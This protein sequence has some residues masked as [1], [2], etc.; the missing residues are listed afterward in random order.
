MVKDDSLIDSRKRLFSGGACRC[1][2]IAVITAALLLLVSFCALP[3][4]FGTSDDKAIQNILSGVTYGFP[5]GY[6]VFSNILL[7]AP[8]ASLY[9]V[10]HEVPLWFVT[11]EVFQFIAATVFCYSCLCIVTIACEGRGRGYRIAACAIS[12]AACIILFLLPTIRPTFSL[13]SACLAASSV[14]AFYSSFFGKINSSHERS[15]LGGCSAALI[16]CAYCVRS[17]SG[18]AGLVILGALFLSLCW[19]F[20]SGAYG[21]ERGDFKRALLVAIAALCLIGFAWGAQK[22]AYSSPEWVEFQQINSVRGK[23]MDYDHD[24]YQN[25]PDLYESVGWDESLYQLVQKW[26]FMDDRVGY[27]SFK[28][29]AK[30]SQV[31][32]RASI[33]AVVTVGSN[34]SD[35]AKS[36]SLALAVALF[37]LVLLVK[38]DHP[39]V[40]TM[41]LLFAASLTLLM[42]LITAGRVPLRAVLCVSLPSIGVLLIMTLSG[43]PQIARYPFAQKDIVRL[44]I[45]FIL[46]GCYGVVVEIIRRFAGVSGWGMV[47]VY[48]T[49]LCPMVN[50]ALLVIAHKSGQSRRWLRIGSATLAF[51]LFCPYLFATVNYVKASYDSN[52]NGCAAKT[53]LYDFANSN[54]DLVI[55]TPAS[56]FSCSKFHRHEA[57]NVITWGGWAYHTPYKKALYRELLDC[58][59][60]PSGRVLVDN[61]KVRFATVGNQFV[62]QLDSY[63]ESLTGR[64]IDY[65]V[66]DGLSNDVNIISFRYVN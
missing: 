18:L 38:R 45:A 31:E 60:D 43:L 53:A 1:F 58:P 12:C 9:G 27:E 29:L 26:Y 19:Q 2:L 63:L 5:S 66:T 22:I 54:P 6:T 25:N 23:Y 21:I 49:L 37:S 64:E 41:L 13:T 32:K 35:A 40:I 4:G 44:V 65:S 30:N 15:V 7:C 46:P 36:L 51:L 11:L 57:S 28:T 3:L 62:D 34:A 48:V 61:Q 50:C 20:F 16:F 14:A 52:S 10:I 56:G 47:P 33:S 42:Y 24:T 17:S 8:L 59:K 55:I 39:S